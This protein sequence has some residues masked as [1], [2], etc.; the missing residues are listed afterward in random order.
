M[1]ATGMMRLPEQG[2][3]EHQTPAVLLLIFNR[4]VLTS[5]VFSAIRKA[6]PAR[7]YIAADGPRAGR[8]GEAEKVRAARAVATAVDWDCEVRTLFREANL[9]CKRAVSSAIDWFFEHEE[10]GI[11]LEDDCLPDASFFPFCAEVLARY[12]DN[13]RVGAISGTNFFPRKAHQHS[14]YFTAQTH[15]WGWASWR[16]AW[17]GYDRTMA[18]WAACEQQRF[19]GRFL[20]RPGSPEYWKGVFDSVSAGEIDTWDYQW[21][22][23]CWRSELLTVMPRVNLIANIGFGREASNTRRRPWYAASFAD[24]LS[25]PLR[26]P[27]RIEANTDADQQIESIYLTETLPRRIIRRLQHSWKYRSGLSKWLS[28]S[29]A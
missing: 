28:P 3:R 16:R 15:I 9:G 26:H 4:P 11:I 12:R 21:L 22:Y 19:L 6:T 10:E 5:Q 24:R 25:A 20:S 7:L 14:Y 13:P 18:S 8:E 23:A 2:M 17:K 1:N 27:T 29:S